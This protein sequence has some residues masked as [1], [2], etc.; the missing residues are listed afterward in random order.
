LSYPEIW[1]AEIVAGAP[2]FFGEADAD[3]FGVSAGEIVALGFAEAEGDSSGD[4]DG[5]GEALR[6]FFLLALGE[7]SGEGLG[8]D[9]F[10][11]GEEVAAASG[12]SDGVGV[13]VV[14]FFFGEAD[15][16]GV[17]LSFGVGDFSAVAFFFLRGVGVGVGAKIFFSLFPSDSSAG[18]R[19]TPKPINARIKSATAGVIVRRINCR[20]SDPISPAQRARPC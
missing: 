4:G 13:A 20:Q 14:F 2:F 12:V 8:D 7:D 16:S 18:A 10:F 17:G 6:F 19:T 9:F 15:F 11:F 5:V 3:G 1:L